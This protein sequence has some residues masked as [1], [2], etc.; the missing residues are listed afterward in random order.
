MLEATRD[1]GLLIGKGGLY[2]NCLRMSPPLTLGEADAREGLGLLVDA[3]R[4]TL[5]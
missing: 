1:R 3:I 2:G 5:A 4:A